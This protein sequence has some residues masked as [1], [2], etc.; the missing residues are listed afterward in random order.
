M[1][2]K[3]GSPAR[4]GAADTVQGARLAGTLLM[5]VSSA[6]SHEVGNSDVMAGS[7]NNDSVEQ[8]QLSTNGTFTTYLEQ[9]GPDTEA[10]SL[11]YAGGSVP[12]TTQS[13]LR[14]QV[15]SIPSVDGELESHAGATSMTAL[16]ARPPR[17]PTARAHSSPAKTAG[18]RFVGDAGEEDESQSAAYTFVSPHAGGAVVMTGDEDADG[19]SEED[20]APPVE[21]GLRKA[22]QH[23]AANQE[24]P[25][26]EAE[27]DNDDAEADM[28]FGPQ[29]GA[30][31]SDLMMALSGLKFRSGVTIQ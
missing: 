5:E 1:A 2:L 3:A 27:V 9:P 15:G 28:T 6:T 7:S 8:T 16:S 23:Q 20:E 18:V 4:F 14:L 17:P 22:K 25:G 12:T 30:S 21:G 10:P 13:S 29:R 11:Q 19:S 31:R 26:R 24:V